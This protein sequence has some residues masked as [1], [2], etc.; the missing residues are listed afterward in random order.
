MIKNQEIQLVITTSNESRGE[1]NDARDIR[2]ASLASRVT[3]HTTI[4]GGNAAVEGIRH[5]KEAQVY[6]L[7][8]MHAEAC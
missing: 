5:M 4:A 8:D 2:M 3:Y 6:A 1:M 7:Q